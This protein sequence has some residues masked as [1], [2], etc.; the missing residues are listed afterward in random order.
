MFT[1]CFSHSAY[2]Y[3][4]SGSGF[5]AGLSMVSKRCLLDTFSFCRGLV[6]KSSSFSFIA[7]LSS[8]RLKKVW[9]LRAAMI[10]PGDQDARLDLRF[11]PCFFHPRRDDRRTV[12]DHGILVGGIEV[13]LVAAG[14]GHAR[15]H[16]VG[17]HDLG[18]RTHV[19]ESMDVGLYP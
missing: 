16:V 3:R 10:A 2:S 17:N 7:L 1:L 5:M 11:V 9:F 15:P 12:V 4:L 18:H 8:A 13:G 14:M 6:L 19:L